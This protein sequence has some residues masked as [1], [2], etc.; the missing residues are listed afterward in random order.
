MRDAL[1]WLGTLGNRGPEAAARQGDA[2]IRGQTFDGS[3]EALARA[4]G[5]GFA[6]GVGEVPLRAWAGP[7]RSAYGVHVV[8]VDAREPGRTPML[9][10]V[11]GRVLHRWLRERRARQEQQ[12]MEALRARYEVE[13]ERK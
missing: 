7:V 3:R 2:F 8:W 12:A 11:R 9:A 5:A 10:D 1:G 13:V 6:A 4:Y